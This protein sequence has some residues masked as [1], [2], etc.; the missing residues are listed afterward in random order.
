MTT[1]GITEAI[2]PE[3]LPGT[4]GKQSSIGIIGTNGNAFSEDVNSLAGI[5]LRLASPEISGNKIMIGNFTGRNLSQKGSLVT[6]IHLGQK[7]IIQT[8]FSISG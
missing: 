7:L 6:T 8:I 4:C 1:N 3:G 2:Q 5:D